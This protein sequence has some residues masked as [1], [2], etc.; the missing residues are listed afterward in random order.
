VNSRAEPMP[1]ATMW[2]VALH[3]GVTTLAPFRAIAAWVSGCRLACPGCCAPETWRAGGVAVLVERLA[4]VIN[5]Q[6]PGVGV[7]LSGGEITDQASA[8][9]RLLRLVDASRPRVMY[10]GLTLTEILR[11]P[12]PEVA[13]LIDLVDLASLG[14]FEQSHAEAGPMRGSTNQ[15]VVAPSGRLAVPTQH[16]GVELRCTGDAIEVIGIPPP[17]FLAKWRAAA[18]TRGLELRTDPSTDI[19]YHLRADERARRPEEP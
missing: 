15:V 7:V 3:Y 4:A 18:S 6:P 11:D 16:L 14:R 13:R 10:S 1:S 8:A 12:R 5:G 19:P 2:L 9:E 17:E